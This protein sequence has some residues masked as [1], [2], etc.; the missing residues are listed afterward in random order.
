MGWGRSTGQGEVGD[1]SVSL[2]LTANIFQSWRLQG[3]G[4]QSFP[5]HTSF[6]HFVHAAQRKPLGLGQSGVSPA[7]PS[8]S[9]VI[10]RGGGGGSL[11][12]QGPSLAKRP[13]SELLYPFLIPCQFKMGGWGRRPG[14]WAPGAL[15]YSAQISQHL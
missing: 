8:L 12:G 10:R 15:L 6:S 11:E 14:V 9:P 2:S 3:K 4:N 13:D 7:R 1:C 5:P